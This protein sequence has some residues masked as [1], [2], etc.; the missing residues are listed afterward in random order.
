MAALALANGNYE[1]YNTY[2]RMALD[3]PNSSNSNGTS[4]DQWPS[5]GD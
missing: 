1:I 5:N 3:D 2:S 4:I